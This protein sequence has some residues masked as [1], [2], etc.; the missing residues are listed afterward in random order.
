MK[1]TLKIVFNLENGKTSTLNLLN[2]KNDLGADEVKAFATDAIDN[3]TIIVDGSKVVALKKAYI[4]TVE[5][6]EIVAES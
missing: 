1:S 5:E 2:P 3:E 4:S 6:K